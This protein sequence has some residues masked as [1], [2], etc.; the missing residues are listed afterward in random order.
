MT[1]LGNVATTPFDS[2][3]Q[4]QV[5]AKKSNVREKLLLKELDGET[6]L[7]VLANAKT[8]LTTTEQVIAKKSSV[9]GRLQ[10]LEKVERTIPIPF[11]GR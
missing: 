8:D 4:N 3:Q 11:T 7:S 5:I 10:S 6:I 1:G 9:S 2:I